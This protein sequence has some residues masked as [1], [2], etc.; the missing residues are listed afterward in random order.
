[1]LRLIIIAILVV[2]CG[3]PSANNRLKQQMVDRDTLLPDTFKRREVI[4]N[5]LVTEGDTLYSNGI[6]SYKDSIDNKVQALRKINK[7]L[8][9]SSEGGE[10]ILYLSGKDTLKMNITFYGET[11]KSVYVFYLRGGYPV[12]Y[13]GTTNVY[14][15]PINISKDAKI[16]STTIDKITLRNNVIV[17]WLQNGRKVKDNYEDKEKEVRYLYSEIRDLLRQ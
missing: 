12:L 7:R 15:E 3:N 9:G 16:D 4:T 10:A 13:I 1:M 14:N 11:G 6:L 5:S 8:E 17:S 2:S